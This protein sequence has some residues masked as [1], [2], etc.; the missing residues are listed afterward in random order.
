MK[1]LWDKYCDAYWDGRIWKIFEKSTRRLLCADYGSVDVIDCELD[2]RE[3]VKATLKK[4]KNGVEY[5]RVV[6]A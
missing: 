1:T 5:W 4:S 2:D 3:F 6:V